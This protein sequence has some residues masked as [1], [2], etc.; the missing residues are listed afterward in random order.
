MPGACPVW[1]SLEHSDFEG[2][3]GRGGGGNWQHF[4]AAASPLATWRVKCCYLCMHCPC[5]VWPRTR[6]QQVHHGL[7]PRLVIGSDCNQPCLR[8]LARRVDGFHNM[9][10][11][12]MQLETWRWLLAVVSCGW[13]KDSSQTKQASLVDTVIVRPLGFD[14]RSWT[15][16]VLSRPGSFPVRGYMGFRNW[17]SPPDPGRGPGP[18]RARKHRQRTS[19]CC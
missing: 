17:R 10:V 3:P 2:G 11:P 18:I 6:W 8:F 12:L 19:D 5:L 15:T 13:R 1:P 14:F 16:P 9:K 4:S 7:W